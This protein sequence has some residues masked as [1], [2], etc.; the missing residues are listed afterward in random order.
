MTEHTKEML[1]LAQR[2]LER[3]AEAAETELR[4]GRIGAQ[5][6]F[7]HGKVDHIILETTAQLK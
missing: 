2:G 1:R 5:I 4:H 7:Q 3:Q 6:V